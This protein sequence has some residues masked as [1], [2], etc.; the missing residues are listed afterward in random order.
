LVTVGD[1]TDLYL[2]SHDNDF[3]YE[4]SENVLKEFLREEWDN[5]K[6]SKLHDYSRIS[7]FFK[8]CFPYI[9]IAS[10]LEADYA[11]LALS[12]S[13]SYY[14]LLHREVECD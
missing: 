12:S 1:W 13:G 7:D 14:A 9:K 5:K 8:E 6:S 11:I 3:R 4:L 2:V 10:E